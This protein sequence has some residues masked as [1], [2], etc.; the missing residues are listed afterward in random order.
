MRGRIAACVQARSS[1]RTS[2]AI[3]HG[4]SGQR[5]RRGA[6]RSLLRLRIL[7]AMAAVLP[8]VLPAVLRLRPLSAVLQALLWPRILSAVLPP[9]LLR[10]L[11]PALLS[12]LLR[13]SALLPAGVLRPA[14]LRRLS[15]LRLS[16]LRLSRLRLSRVLPCSL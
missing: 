8:T 7:P 6:E 10:R 9:R 15:R 4:E 2:G 16:R 14:L 12:A 1:N 3:G 11:L 5:H 13:L